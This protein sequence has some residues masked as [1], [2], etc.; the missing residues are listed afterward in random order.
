M[1]SSSSPTPPAASAST[2]RAPSRS[3]GGPHRMRP[4]RSSPTP[5]LRTT[6]PPSPPT[7]PRSSSS[8]TATTSGPGSTPCSSASAA[9][10]CARATRS[11]CISATAATARPATAC[12]PRAK[13]RSGSRC[14]STPSR[15]TT[16]S[17]CRARPRS[18]WCRGRSCA[19]RR[20]CRRCARAGAPFRLAVVGEDRWGN[21]SEKANATLRLIADRPVEGLPADARGEG[22][23]R[24]RRGRRPLR[25]GGGRS[26]DRALQPGRHAACPLQPAAHRRRARPQPLLGRSARPERRDRRH[27]HRR[28]ILPLRARQG[29]RRHRRPPG[30]RFSDRHG[31]LGR[32]Q[33]HRR[34]ARRARQVR[35]AAGLR[36]VR[37]HR[38]GRRSQRFFPAS[39]TGRSSALRASCLDEDHDA[40]ERLPQRERAVREAGRRGRGRD[41][42]CRRPLRRPSRRPRRPLRARGRGALLLGHLRVAPARCLRSRPSRRRG[43]PQRRPQGPARRRLARRRPVRRD[44]RPHLLPDAKARPARPCSR[45]CAG[46]ITTAPP[47]RASISTSRPACPTVPG[48]SRTTPRLGPTA[49][50]PGRARHDGRYRP[51]RRRGDPGGRRGRARRRSSASWC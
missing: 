21:P 41:R 13:N 24:H 32:D 49:S 19:G 43:L 20:S 36:V 33:P 40:G 44:R 10:S 31:A 3:A 4:S 46:A 23:Q 47:A 38:H 26:A 42:P 34:R 39:R 17:S 9:A 18:S 27:R 6:R 35:G 45:P 29:V 7:A 30:Q 51:G 22:R 16:S 37:Q 1:P 48:C 11:S 25:A 12:R 8:T 5:R 15:P 50:A 2:I 14:S 28:R